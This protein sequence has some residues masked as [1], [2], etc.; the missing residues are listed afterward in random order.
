MGMRSRFCKVQRE[1][2]LGEKQHM[3]R[4]KWER[5]GRFEE[6]NEG[7]ETRGWRAEGQWSDR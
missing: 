3:Q 4:L 7:T 5:A 2:V 1:G 6:P